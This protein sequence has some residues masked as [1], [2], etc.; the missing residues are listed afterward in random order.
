VTSLFLTD[1]EMRELT[2]RARKGD[3]VAWLRTSGIPYHVNAAGKPIVARAH[4]TREPVP[5]NAPAWA[6]APIRRQG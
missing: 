6:P 3:Q 1:D 5:A 2:G 4:F